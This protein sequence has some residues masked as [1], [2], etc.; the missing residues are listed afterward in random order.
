MSV[1]VQGATPGSDPRV[2]KAVVVFGSLTLVAALSLGGLR[3]AR[4]FRADTE[5]SATVQEREIVACLERELAAA[6]RPGESVT[7]TVDS[8]GDQSMFLTQRSSEILYPRVRIVAHGGEAA[9]VVTEAPLPEAC[10]VRVSPPH[11]T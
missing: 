10:V 8:A 6:T 2:A 5:S 9:I 1:A 3:F 11:G 4:L 7:L